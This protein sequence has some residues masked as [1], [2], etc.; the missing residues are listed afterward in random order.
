V[1][2]GS[3]AHRLVRQRANAVFRSQ[4]AL[5]GTFIVTT[6]YQRQTRVEELPM[7]PRHALVAAIV[8]AG[9][10]SGCDFGHLGHASAPVDQCRS[11]TVSHYLNTM[12]TPEAR[13]YI[14]A[15]VGDRPIRYYTI[16]D[17]V[18]QDY[19]PARLNVELG[20]DGRIK[21]LRCG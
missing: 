5:F 17:P 4:A 15:R 14:A 10:A 1:A 16:G 9:P 18:T 6:G 19:N 11:Q 7:K 2:V 21:R 12:P 20:G 3:S 8:L 13:A